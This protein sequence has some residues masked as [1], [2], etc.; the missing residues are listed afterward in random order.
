M[1]KKVLV[2]DDEI[3]ITLLIKEGLELKGFQIESYNRSPS[4]FARIQTQL[5]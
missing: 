5:L 2:V 1:G 3:D 4:G